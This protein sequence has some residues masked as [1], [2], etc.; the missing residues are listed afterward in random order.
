VH[1]RI[2]RRTLAQRLAHLMGGA[3]FGMV[4]VRDAIAADKVCADPSAMDAGQQ[5]LRSS[6]NYVES[7]PDHSKTC[8][9]CAFFQATDG[10]CGTCTIFNGPA[11]PA[12]H[13]DSWS[14][15]S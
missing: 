13:C 7:A 1:H 3:A 5:G 14:A 11:N 6:L 10:N 4:L 12:G 2:S 9:K 15:K 8:S